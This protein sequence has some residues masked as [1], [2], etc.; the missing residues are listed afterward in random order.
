MD[1]TE[2][3]PPR[4]SRHATSSELAKKTLDTS[5]ALYARLH[6]YPE[7][8]EKRASRLERER[9]IHERSKLI[10]ELEELR[11]RGWVYNPNNHHQNLGASSSASAA[12]GGGADDK[13]TTIRGGRAEEE[14]Q[15][16]LRE[17]EERLKR[18]DALL[19][20]QPRKSNFLSVASN[21]LTANASSAASLP[22]ANT[23]GSVSGYTTTT[24]MKKSQSPASFP[25]PPGASS[26]RSSSLSRRQQYVPPA[27]AVNEKPRLDGPGSTNRRHPTP[28]SATS[29]GDGNGSSM[30][31][32]KI[33][34]DQD[35]EQ[36][37]S[38]PRSIST[39]EKKQRNKGKAKAAHPP[40]ARRSS[41][42]SNPSRDSVGE[43][44]LPGRSSKMRTVN[45]AET[46]DD[47]DEGTIGG[48]HAMDI[49]EFKQESDSEAPH[50]DLDEGEGGSENKGQSSTRRQ[51][52]PRRIS[53]AS[54]TAHEPPASE[55][56]AKRHRPARHRIRSSFFHSETMR[57]SVY[58]QLAASGPVPAAAWR[59]YKV[60]DRWVPHTSPAVPSQPRGRSSW[61]KV[62]A[63]GTSLPDG[64]EKQSEFEPHGG[65]Y[66][67]PSSYTGT[68]SGESD[69][70]STKERWL[71]IGLE[72]NGR[73]NPPKMFTR[74]PV[75]DFMMDRL[76]KRGERN[77]YVVL[78]GRILPKSA[79]DAWTVDPLRSK[80]NSP[81]DSPNPV[82][83]V[84][85]SVDADQ[86]GIGFDDKLENR[87]DDRD[88]DT[89][90]PPAP[91][92]PA[93]RPAPIAA[94]RDH[95]RDEA[96]PRS[97]PSLGRQD[98]PA[99]SAASPPPTTT[100]FGFA[101]PSVTQVLFASVPRVRSIPRTDSMDVD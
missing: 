95:P 15:R 96:A 4:T 29:T 17:G 92:R 6:R 100:G 59:S 37:R 45:Y 13:T 51:S 101:L 18:Y 9:L 7:V 47:D 77:E 72:P 81:V 69:S 73:R 99:P 87:A 49:D 58:P 30:L 25:P 52:A 11:G 41:S 78:D 21:T 31:K 62:Y 79:V 35:Q 53:T 66:S 36:N 5:D 71:R 85:D 42:A 84:T 50:S 88:D 2:F 80:R 34:F 91:T 57:D 39:A 14:R 86:D 68:D 60:K 24:T 82:Q 56:N 19:P 43:R 27:I 23:L 3:L 40:S 22:A 83:S 28:L 63:F 61:R 74:R 67:S 54:S 8:L 16:K 94:S 32:I 93:P 89:A 65:G 44:K 10:N 48:D 98:A 97:T 20:N 55:T 64:L 46:D 26:S 33:K 76:E 38:A 70:D 90:P 1:E 12:G 75:E